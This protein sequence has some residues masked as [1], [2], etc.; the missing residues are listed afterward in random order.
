MAV[1][2]SFWEGLRAVWLRA[3]RS[4][5]NSL[6]R[7]RT[8]FQPVSE[9]PTGKMPVLQKP[10]EPARLEAKFAVHDL[11]IVH[12]VVSACSAE[13]EARHRALIRLSQIDFPNVA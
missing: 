8:G 12:G 1:G 5:T 11:V 3:V 4:T 6:A 9:D 2:G 13:F 10:T 7:S